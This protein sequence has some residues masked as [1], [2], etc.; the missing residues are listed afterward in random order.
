MVEAASQDWK[1][2]VAR[3]NSSTLKALDVL[4]LLAEAEDGLRLTDIAAGTGYPVSTARRLLIGLIERN[5]V[6]QDPKTSR[7][8]PGTKILTLQAHGIRRRH[9]GRRAYPQLTRLRQQLDETVNLGVL[10]ETS[11]IYLETLVPDSSIGFYAPPGTRMP[12]HCTAMG[13]VLLATLPE[14]ARESALASLDLK[15]YTPRTIVDP[16]A[17]RASLA[18][19]V[20]RGYAVDDEEFAVGVRCLAAP[21]RDHT[22]GVVAG[23]SVTALAARMPP[24]RDAAVAPLVLE[25]ARQISQSLGFAG[26]TVLERVAPA[27]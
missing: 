8:Y 11:V 6:E 2:G 13:R 4:E 14:T 24:A 9:I 10:S 15:P 12:L 16:A 1:L 25:A 5:Y 27:S 23:V 3:G 19:V 17:L 21:I 22:G 18:G 26:S 20:E 7:Y